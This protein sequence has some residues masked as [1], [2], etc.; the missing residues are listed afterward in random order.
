MIT[1]I[2]V[3]IRVCAGIK[4]KHS[5]EDLKIMVGLALYANVSHIFI[6]CES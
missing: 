5:F 2:I 1:L 3:I 4:T 6:I